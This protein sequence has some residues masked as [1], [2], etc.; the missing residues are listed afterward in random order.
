M[1]TISGENLFDQTAE[2][3]ATSNIASKS[4]NVPQNNKTKDT[5]ADEFIA[6]DNDETDIFDYLA[7]SKIN[8]SDLEEVIDDILPEDHE[9]CFLDDLFE[10][11]PETPEEQFQEAEEEHEEYHEALDQAEEKSSEADREQRI[12]EDLKQEGEREI[13]EGEALKQKALTLTDPKTGELTPE[14]TLLLSKGDGLITSGKSKVSQSST[15]FS[16]AS[17]LRSE[18]DALYSDANSHLES[19]S[20]AYEQ[21]GSYKKSFE[22]KLL[23]SEVEF[24]EKNSIIDFFA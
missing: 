14:A 23:G 8:Y 12:A 20:S 15:H 10:G 3:S 9:Y 16:N 24:E 11:S 7:N 18:A 21:S 19:S 22:G 1:S 4:N 6:K 2:L 5:K 13:K 17:S